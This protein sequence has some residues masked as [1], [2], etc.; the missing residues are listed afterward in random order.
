MLDINKT[1][2]GYIRI[3]ENIVPYE[4]LIQW[5]IWTKICYKKHNSFKNNKFISYECI[6]I[7]WQ[8]HNLDD[9]YIDSDKKQL[10]LKKILINNDL[11]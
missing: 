7:M 1:K 2:E 8:Q 3:E 10:T 11:L 5:T 9:V 4:I 6:D